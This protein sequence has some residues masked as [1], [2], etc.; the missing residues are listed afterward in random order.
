MYRAV[1]R[2]AP[3]LT[4]AL[5]ICG[6]QGSAVA[7]RPTAPINRQTT[8]A[9]R[10]GPKETPARFDAV[11]RAERLAESGR[12]RA[13]LRETSAVLRR[14]PNAEASYLKGRLLMGQGKTSEALAAWED[15]WKC[16]PPSVAAGVALAR[17]DI[18]RQNWTAAAERLRLCAAM[19]PDDAE[20][21]HRL[22]QAY[23]GS[24]DLED[25][26]RSLERAVAL[27]DDG[28]ERYLQLAALRQQLGDRDAARRNHRTGLRLDPEHPLLDRVEDLLRTPPTAPVSRSPYRPLEG[29]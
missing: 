8:M 20:I 5:V 24:G 12:P 13:A 16:Q 26:A 22:A 23:A 10:G 27:G 7:L 15:A 17:W 25:A 11:G 6:C 29:P 21:Q 2:L 1:V 19:R 14:E 3:T 18:R 9:H 28:P 4:A